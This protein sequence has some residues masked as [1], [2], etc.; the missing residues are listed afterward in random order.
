MITG[1]AFRENN[2][3]SKRDKNK[4]IYRIL[5]SAQ[6]VV[7]NFIEN[8]LKSDTRRYEKNTVRIAITR[9]FEKKLV[10]KSSCTNEYK[11]G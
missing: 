9:E 10:K 1:S 7:L 3:S 5:L 8:I 11:C 6:L 2:I 4:K